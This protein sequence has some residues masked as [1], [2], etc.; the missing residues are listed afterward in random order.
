[1]Y[2]ERKGN[3]VDDEDFVRVKM[4]PTNEIDYC[5]PTEEEFYRAL[6]PGDTLTVTL[7]GVQ[8]EGTVEVSE[9]GAVTALFSGKQEGEQR[10]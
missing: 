1:M 6:K 9:G 5:Y 8:Y 3:S 4:M 7:D 2:I 10:G